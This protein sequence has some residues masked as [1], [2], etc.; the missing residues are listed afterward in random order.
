MERE[1]QMGRRKA[2][3]GPK[4]NGASNEITDGGTKARVQIFEEISTLP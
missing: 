4:V 1:C 3:V 2:K